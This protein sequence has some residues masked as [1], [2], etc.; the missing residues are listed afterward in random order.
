M[1]AKKIVINA[2]NARLGRLAS[3]A[4]KQALLGNDVFIVNCN[5][6]VITGNRRSVIEEYKHKRQRGGS[7][8]KGPHFPEHVERVVKRT[9]RGMLSYKQGRGLAAFKKIKCY[10]N[11]PEQFKSEMKP[12]T[13]QKPTLARTITMEDLSSEI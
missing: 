5:A 2:E 12:F 6:A 11:I 8:L 13:A 9:I 7:S 10:S 3:Y 4:A 1:T